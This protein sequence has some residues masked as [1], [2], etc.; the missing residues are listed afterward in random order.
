MQDFGQ[1]V[2]VLFAT[3][4]FTYVVTSLIIVGWS[5]LDRRT[6]EERVQYAITGFLW[7]TAVAGVINFLFID[8][9]ARVVM[10]LIASTGG[11]VLARSLR[12]GQK[13]K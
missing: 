5:L 10:F 12:T 2:Q 13:R 1:Y 3:H 9:P 4:G 7:C 8:T 6:K 11:V